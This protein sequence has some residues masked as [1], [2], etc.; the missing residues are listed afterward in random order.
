V[1]KLEWQTSLQQQ[2]ILFVK[3]DNKISVRFNGQIKQKVIIGV[4]TVRSLKIKKSV[5]IQLIWETTVE[6]D[7]LFSLREKARMTGSK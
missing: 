4:F 1:L 6:V 2:M 7:S 3:R 5:T